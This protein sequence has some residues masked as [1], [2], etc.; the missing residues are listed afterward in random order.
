MLMLFTIII[1]VV[2]VVYKVV[3]CN[4]V[5]HDKV[6]H[7]DVYDGI[8][9]EVICRSRRSCLLSFTTMLFVGVYDDVRR[10]LLSCLPTVM[11]D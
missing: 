3:V 4:V 7:D 5:V 11:M 9:C 8:V 6:V 10:C 1:I 2:V